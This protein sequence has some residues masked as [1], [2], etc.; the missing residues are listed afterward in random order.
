[1]LLKIR[2][3]IYI[4][5]CNYLIIFQNNSK[6]RKTLAHSET[7]WSDV[8]RSRQKKIRWGHPCSLPLKFMERIIIMIQQNREKEEIDIIDFFDGIGTTTMASMKLKAKSI[9][10]EYDPEYYQICRNLLLVRQFNNL[11]NLFYIIG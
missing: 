5:K 6:A 10:I 7:I 8:F 3:L 4:C 9:G 2:V 11:L 1:M